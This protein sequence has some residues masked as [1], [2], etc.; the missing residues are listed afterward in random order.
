LLVERESLYKVVVITAAS[1][2]PDR[3]QDAKE[4]SEKAHLFYLR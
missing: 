3:E 1:G 2:K 4:N